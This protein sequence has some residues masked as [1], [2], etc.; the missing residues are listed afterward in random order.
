MV[1]CILAAA[2]LD[3]AMLYADSTTAKLRLPSRCLP[4]RI[5]FG[6]SIAQ[7]VIALSL[8]KCGGTGLPNAFAVSIQMICAKP[9][10]VGGVPNCVIQRRDVALP[11]AGALPAASRMGR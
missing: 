10:G 6:R 3:P 9:S 7:L 5:C 8:K 1:C 11:D 4:A 2:S